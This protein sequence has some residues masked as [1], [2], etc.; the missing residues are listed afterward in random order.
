[1]YLY[2]HMHAHARTDR[3]TDRQ[4]D[5]HTH[6]H[7]TNLIDGGQISIHVSRETSSA[8]HLFTSSRHLDDVG[9]EHL[10]HGIM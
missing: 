7:S 6:T 2:I 10:S 9:I 4:T 3:Q 5:T 8:R 1:M